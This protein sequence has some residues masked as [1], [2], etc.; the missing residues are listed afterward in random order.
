V[1]G[2]LEYAVALGFQSVT[3][4]FQPTYAFNPRHIE[5]MRVGNAILKE[6]LDLEEEKDK[7][8]TVRKETEKERR[9]AVALSVQLAY[10]DDRKTK[11]EIDEREAELRRIRTAKQPEAPKP[12]RARKMP[13]AGMTLDG[14]EVVVSGAQPADES[15]TSARR[16]Y[17]AQ[18]EDDEDDDEDAM[19]ED[20]GSDKES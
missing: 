9:E 3:Q 11:A 4:N 5:D 16:G 12:K 1:K 7:R 2:A 10:Q 8:S 15:G 17:S 13:S 18:D 20:A 19:E 6:R 14:K